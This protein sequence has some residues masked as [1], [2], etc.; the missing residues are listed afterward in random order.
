VTARVLIAGIGNIF[1]GDDGFGVEV[2]TRL[3]TAELPPDVVA[4][5]FGI[6]GMHLAY[7]MLDGRYA[8]TILV[9]AIS[10]G[11]APGTLSVIEAVPHQ[12]PDGQPVPQ[13][14]EGTAVDPHGMHPAAV[15]ELLRRLGGA[16]GRVLVV[17]CEPASVAEGI[18][19]SEPVAAMVDE[20]VRR[21]QDLAAAAVGEELSTDVPRHSR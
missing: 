15:L 6:R 5:D 1:L 10:R 17:G 19:L 14:R 7:E 21:T 12:E 4:A 16:P 8:T 2:A 9:D 18:G 3:S 20:A 11:G 13:P